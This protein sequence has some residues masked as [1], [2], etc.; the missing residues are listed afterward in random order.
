M[1]VATQHRPFFEPLNVF[2]Q[3]AHRF[4]QKITCLFKKPSLIRLSLLGPRSIQRKTFVHQI[5]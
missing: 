3:Y 4:G 1:F 5:D 2:H